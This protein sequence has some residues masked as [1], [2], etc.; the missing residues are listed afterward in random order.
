MKNKTRFFAIISLVTLIGF[1]IS[2]CSNGGLNQVDPGSLFG[3]WTITWVSSIDG[4]VRS[5]EATVNRASFM[6]KYTYGPVAGRRF[7]M[8]IDSWTPVNCEVE[9]IKGQVVAS[10]KITGKVTYKDV[11]GFTALAN[12]PNEQTMYIHLKQGGQG[13]WRSRF[14]TSAGDGEYA[15]IR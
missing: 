7:E 10:Y 14:N 13:M 12:P 2:A 4:S 8:G 15:K 3:T 6:L 11:D 5:E 1:S 9:S